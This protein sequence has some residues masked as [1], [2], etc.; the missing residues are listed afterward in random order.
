MHYTLKDH[1]GNQTAT[2]H[3]NTMER[4]TQFWRICNSPASNISICNARHLRSNKRFII[5]A[6][7]TNMLWED[8]I[9]IS[10]I[11]NPQVLPQRMAYPL[12]LGV[13]ANY[14]FNPDQH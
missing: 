10:G 14:R 11:A 6:P 12:E 2:I 3:G 1:Q 8:M 5:F 4:M 13:Y 9:H 7:K